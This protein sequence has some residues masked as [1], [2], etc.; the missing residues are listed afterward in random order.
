MNAEHKDAFILLAKQ[1]AGI[2][3]QDAELTS[4]DRLGF[5][6]RLKTQNGIKGT[7]ISFSQEVSDPAQTRKAFV[8]IVRQERQE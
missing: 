1:C 6:L 3:A 4:V 7:R 8:E 2:E 5:H